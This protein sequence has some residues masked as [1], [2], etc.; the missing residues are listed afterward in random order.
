MTY[1]YGLNFKRSAGDEIGE[2][3]DLGYIL[4]SKGLAVC[5]G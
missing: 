1:A 5:E 3:Y 4:G 2:R